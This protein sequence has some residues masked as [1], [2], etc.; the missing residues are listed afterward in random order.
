MKPV[1]DVISAMHSPTDEDIA[2]ITRAYEFGKKAHEG[3]FRNSGE[4]Y[5]I[6]PIETAITLASL[7][8]GKV[9]VAAGLLHDS[10]ED[11]KATEADVEREFGK[12]VLFLVK[13]VTKLGTLKYHGIER[14]AES[15]RRFLI[16]TSED[17]RVVIIKLADRLHNMKTLEHVRADKRERIAKE[18]LEIYVPIAERLGMGNL[19]R[20]LEDLAFPYVF[21]KAYEETVH[22]IAEKKHE[23]EAEL[24]KVAKSLKKELAEAGIRDFRSEIRVKGLYSLHQ[25]LQRRGGDMSLI[26]DIL[27]VRIIVPT[28]D[29]CYRVLGIVH[30]I[31]RPLPGRIKDYIAFPKPNGYQ[32][33]HTTVLIGNGISVELQIRTEDMHREAQFGVASHFGYKQGFQNDA[34]EIS[35]G[36]WIRALIPNLM[37]FRQVQAGMLKSTETEDAAARAAP[38]WIRDIAEAGNI[39]PNSEEFVESLKGDF[40]IHRV[41]VFTPTGDVIDLPVDASPIDF[42]YAIHSDIGNHM[43]GVKANGKLVPLDT[44]LKN[45][46]V[47]EIITK[48]SAH[49]SSKWLD[50]AKTTLAK[51]H[52]RSELAARAKEKG[53]ER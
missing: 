16:A 22:I 32:S 7:G 21:P 4:P 9:T 29:D 33:L 25:K 35:S 44:A 37:K 42:A 36:A 6:H 50:M 27:A 8:L 17:I 14:H 11:A 13:G 43:S 10:I 40:F 38:R 48:P 52:I 39:M 2:F 28:V 20:D 15:L 45:G 49:P 19:R 12:E 46:D 3:H 53:G 41:F 31:W 34:R 24:E 47:V 18:T 51:R 5:F 1:K 23:T 26:H 30:G